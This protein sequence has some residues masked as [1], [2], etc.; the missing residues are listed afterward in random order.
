MLSTSELNTLAIIASNDR[1][2]RLSRTHLEKLSR[3]DLIEP[4]AAGP[5]VSI[6]GREILVTRK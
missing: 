3:L 1:S 4:G 6:K 5:A 2:E